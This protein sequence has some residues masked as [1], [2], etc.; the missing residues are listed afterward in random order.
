MLK[1]LDGITMLK[2]IEDDQLRNRHSI[3]YHVLCRL[4]T[5]C[6]PAWKAQLDERTEP[7]MVAQDLRVKTTV[8]S[9]SFVATIGK[10]QT[11]SMRC[12]WN[13]DM[14]TFTLASSLCVELVNFDKSANCI[15]PN[16]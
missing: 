6:C 14:Q 1:Q 13:S 3:C 5:V 11:S 15:Q 16:K 4:A 7:G 12:A 9:L 8:S 2:T 10:Q